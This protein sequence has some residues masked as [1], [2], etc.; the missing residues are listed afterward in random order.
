[1]FRA[2]RKFWNFSKTN[3]NDAFLFCRAA[4]HLGIFQQKQLKL[5]VFCSGCSEN[6]RNLPT[7][8]SQIDCILFSCAEK[9]SNC[10]QEHC[11]LFGAQR[12][13]LEFKTGFCFAVQR[14]TL[15]FVNES[16]SN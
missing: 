11:I 1:L 16:N 12:K 4:K 10:E 6:F 8:T 14:K 3:S 15:E 13:I 2:Q 5:T 9:I 7:K